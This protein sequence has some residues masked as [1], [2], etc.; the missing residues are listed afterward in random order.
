MNSSAGVIQKLIADSWELKHNHSGIKKCAAQGSVDAE[1]LEPLE[2]VALAVERHDGD[3][4]NESPMAVI[5]KA[6]K[7]SDIGVAEGIGEAGPARARPSAR[8][9]RCCRRRS[10]VRAS[11]CCRARR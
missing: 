4:Q 1:K 6:L 2:P 3:R 10:R 5:S 7:T 11:S 8:S 9:V